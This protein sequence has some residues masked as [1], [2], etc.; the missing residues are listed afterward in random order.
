MS[1]WELRIG[2]LSASSQVEEL[3]WTARATYDEARRTWPAH[4]SANAGKVSPLLSHS[5]A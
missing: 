3:G 5:S 2:W 1:A 4:R